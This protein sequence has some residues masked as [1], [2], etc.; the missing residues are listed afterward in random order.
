MDIIKKN[1]NI[2]VGLVV[3]AIAFFVYNTFL[4]SDGT[5]IRPAPSTSGTGAALLKM[6]EALRQA[7]LSQELFSSPG[8][9]RLA[10][11]TVGASEA[12]LG[13]ANPFNPIGS[14]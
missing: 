5:L 12:P 13:R 11:F 6:T 3:F 8:F 1:K 2:I 7:D 14:D 10:D 9:V 4:R